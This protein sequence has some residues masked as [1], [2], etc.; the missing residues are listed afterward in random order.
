[1]NDSGFLTAH[2][3]LSGYYLKSET[4][5]ASQISDALT[6]ISV[7]D[8]VRVSS[9]LTTGTRIGTISVDGV[10]TS[11]YAPEGS[12]VT[13]DNRISGIVGQNDLSIVKLSSSEYATM[14]S[15]HSTLSNCLYVVEESFV[16]AYGSA[17]RNVGEPSSDTDAATKG[18]V[19]GIVPL[20][21]S[22]LTNDSGFIVLSDVQIPTDLSSF[23]NSPGY[24]SSV[25]DTYKTYSETKTSLSSD[26]YSTD[27]DLTAF[28]TKSDTSSS[29]QISEALGGKAN[30]S[31]V[32]L[33][34]S[35]LVND[36][37]FLESSALSVFF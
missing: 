20:S 26:G 17:I 27:A 7:G 32:P 22:Q 16:N 5:S 34:T 2:Q 18:Y 1:M 10:P 3:S 21:T 31:S 29:Q 23:T 35:Q 11:L 4:S 6:S 25:P 9:D 8:S 13:F 12:K 15:T 28:Y 30:I 33:S 19:D 36:S 37:G 24:L 14:L